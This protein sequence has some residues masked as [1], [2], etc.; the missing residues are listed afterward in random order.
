MNQKMSKK[1]WDERAERA[2]QE[3]D[4]DAVCSLG[5]GDILHSYIHFLQKRAILSAIAEVNFQR[6]RTLDVGC[7]T[8]RWSLELKKRG[9]DVTGIDFS[10]KML[11]LANEKSKKE[12]AKV[13][14]I[15]MGSH[16]LGFCDNSFDLILCVT[17][18]QHVLDEKTLQYTI[19]EIVRVTAQDGRILLLELAP[20]K[21]LLI[22]NSKHIR[23]RLSSF[24]KNEFEARGLKLINEAPVDPAP[25]L[26]WLERTAEKIFFKGRFVKDVFPSFSKVDYLRKRISTKHIINLISIPIVAVS[27]IYD[28][29]FTS[30]IPSK[31]MS[32][33]KMFI[34]KRPSMGG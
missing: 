29:P 9:H 4:L 14:Y 30:L 5:L 8:G 3:Y 7:G 1:Y 34:F 22:R 10:K 11:R 25:F 26:L 32:R 16:R 12:S 15:N 13:S 21:G 31:E 18:L 23:E 19:N 24:Y 17:V 2:K 20:R 27:L 33:H 6:I 28:L